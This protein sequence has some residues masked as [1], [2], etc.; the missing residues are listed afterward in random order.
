VFIL[1]KILH[2]NLMNKISGF[3]YTISWFKHIDF[4]ECDEEVYV[5]L[6][7]T[8]K[9][10]F[11]KLYLLYILRLNIYYK[12]KKKKK[13]KKKINKVQIANSLWKVIKGNN[14]T[15]SVIKTYFVISF[16]RILI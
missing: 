14:I 13:K 5:M 7:L 10:I 1:M 11:I 16:I 6:I 2:K 3:W 9:D 8:I 15:L 12:K 4:T